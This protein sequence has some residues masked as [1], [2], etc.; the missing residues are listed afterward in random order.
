MRKLTRGWRLTIFAMLLVALVGCGEESGVVSTP[1]TTPSSSVKTDITPDPS[2]PPTLSQST[3]DTY[4]KVMNEQRTK[5]GGQD[6]GHYGH[7][8]PAPPLGWSD[9]LYHASYEHSYDMAKSDWFSHDGS[10]SAN[11]WTSQVQSLGR[12]SK[13]D[14]RAENNNYTNWR[15]LGENI[16]AGTDMDEA[17]EAVIGWMNSPDHCKNMMNPNFKEVGLSVVY[18]ENSYYKYYWTQDFGTKQY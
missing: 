3:I 13:M 2:S 10:G 18:D 9:E 1:S 7:F 5:A 8:D 11:D 15:Y 14:E 17:R 4:L 6:C 12:G 16:A